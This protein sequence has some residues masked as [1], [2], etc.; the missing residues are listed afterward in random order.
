MPSEHSAGCSTARPSG[1]PMAAPG[2]QGSAGQLPVIRATVA[3]ATSLGL[4]ILAGGLRG[5]GG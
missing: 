2:D 3:M 1:K 4:G 5:A